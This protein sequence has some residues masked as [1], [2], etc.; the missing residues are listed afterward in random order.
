MKKNVIL[1]GPPGSGKGTQAKNLAE[2]FGYTYFGT[3]DMMREE[4][5]LGTDYG[6]IFQNVWDNGK[7]ELIPDDIV[8]KFV[9][10]RFSNLD[11]SRG[12]VF[13]GFPRTLNQ[14][15]HLEKKFTEN[16]E[17]FV[18]FDIEVAD[19]SLVQRMATRKV[20]HNCKKIFF[21]A[22]ISGMKNC[23]TCGGELFR[24]QEDEPVVVQKRLDVYEHETKPLIDFFKAEGK[25][26]EIDGEPNIEDVEKDIISKINEQN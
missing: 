24:R 18:V 2:H 14:A 5:H 9:E 13:D 3:G 21:K 23:D 8:E 12:V 16:G 22:D 15:K 6:K 4:A 17:D 11:F 1:M 10:E 25:L 19:E 20:C 26:I 7:G